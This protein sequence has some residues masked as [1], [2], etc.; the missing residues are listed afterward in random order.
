MVR[1]I[2][3]GLFS[4]RP[5]EQ[6]FFRERTAIGELRITREAIEDIIDGSISR[7]KGLR[8]K[9]IDM[10]Q[11]GETVEISVFCQLADAFHLNQVSVQIQER[12]R[13]DVEK[14]SGIKVREVNVLVTPV[15]LKRRPALKQ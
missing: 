15:R 14:Y 6:V 13:R 12:V 5:K 8:R 9:K 7:I 10:E 1:N 11:I 2:F 3:R 4:S